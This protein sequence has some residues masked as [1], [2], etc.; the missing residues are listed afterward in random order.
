MTKLAKKQVTTKKPAAKMVAKAPTKIPA[1]KAPAKTPAT[2]PDPKTSDEN[3]NFE[4]NAKLRAW[5]AAH[6]DQQKA[7]MAGWRARRKAAADN[8]PSP[9]TSVASTTSDNGSTA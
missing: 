1:K 2:T 5:R 8:A 6:V 7:Y 3:K 4:R 9:G